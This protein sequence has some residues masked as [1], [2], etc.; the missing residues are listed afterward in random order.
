MGKPSVHL[1]LCT[2]VHSTYFS[3]INTSFEVI[4]CIQRKCLDIFRLTSVQI[5]TV[6]MMKMK[7]S[8]TNVSFQ[9]VFCGVATTF[10]IKSLGDV[11]I[12]LSILWHWTSAKWTLPK[13]QMVIHFSSNHFFCFE[14]FG[15]Y[16]HIFYNSLKQKVLSFYHV[17]PF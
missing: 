1:L 11:R 13:L 14:H 12:R 16:V 8:A 9:T 7:H 4:E 3:N 10:E 5:K 6:Q 17:I 15:V 2:L